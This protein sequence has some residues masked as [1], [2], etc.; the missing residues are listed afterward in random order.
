MK[1]AELIKPLPPSKPLPP[2]INFKQNKLKHPNQAQKEIIVNWNDDG[3]IETSLDSSDAFV[4]RII[5]KA[6][7][8]PSTSKNEDD[9]LG[10]FF[11]PPPS[12]PPPILVLRESID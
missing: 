9:L 5:E 3:K 1:F 10:K 6:K 12:S 8:Q 2:P 11:K 7:T 4:N